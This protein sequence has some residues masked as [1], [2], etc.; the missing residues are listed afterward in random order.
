MP[1]GL[2]NFLAGYVRYATHLAAYVL[3]DR[4]PVPGLSRAAA[5]TRWTSRSPSPEPQSAGRR[6]CDCCSRIPALVLA[7]VRGLHGAGAPHRPGRLR[8][9]PSCFGG[10]RRRRRLRVPRLVRSARARPDAA[11]SARPRRATA[12]GLRRQAY[13]YFLL[14]T[15][16]YPNSDPDAIGPEW[17]LPPH[18]VQLELSDDGRRSRLTVF[19][20]L[21]LALPHF[22]WLALWTV[23]AFLAAI[24]ERHRRARARPLRRVA[25]PL[26]RRL[27]PLHGARGRV[28]H[29]GREPVPRLRRRARAIPV[30]IA[31]GP[32]ARQNRWV[33]LF[34]GFLVIP[35]LVV[36]SAVSGVLVLGRPCLG[37]FASL[38]TGR[39]PTG[40][41]NVGALPSA[42]SRRRTRTGSSSPT[43]TRTRARR[44][45][46]PRSPSRRLASRSRSGSGRQSDARGARLTP[47]RPR[48][49]SSACS[50]RSPPGRSGRASSRA[51]L[52]LGHVRL[53]GVPQ[54]TSSGPTATSASSGSNSWSRSSSS[55]ACSLL[56]AKYGITLRQGVGGGPHRHGNASRDDRA[57]A[58]LDLAGARS[59]WRRSGGTAATTRPTAATSRRSSQLVRA[60]R[61]VPVHLSRAR[62]RDGAG[63][64]VPSQLVARSR[65]VLRR[66]RL[67]VRLRLSVPRPPPSRC[68]VPT[69]SRPGAH[70]QRSRGSTRCRSASRT[71]RL[72]ERAERLRRRLSGRARGSSSGTRS[73]TAASPTTR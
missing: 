33:T 51:N 6:R 15:D 54:E 37:W 67:P 49:S 57:R 9:R 31:I 50:G 8:R 24:V 59:A 1:Q 53:A 28:R 73:S 66:A 35:A 26:P 34:R 27:R 38:V 41:R 18:P 61:R 68:A 30:D 48:R 17:S 55:S 23:A 62:R 20:R 11:G 2:H 3:L 52:V 36:S 42:T 16:R 70:T 10:R 21:L 44:F 63:R 7:P 40:L 25:A 72:H 19:F 22:V 69:W 45:A 32:P 14:L 5:D 47:P 58:R 56:Y 46:R 13:A 60:R 29:P 39:M 43:T 64:K 65:T 4:E 12:L 71:S